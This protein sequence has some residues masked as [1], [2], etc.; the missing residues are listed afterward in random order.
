MHTYNREEYEYK[1]AWQEDMNG[2]W[3]TA[4]GNSYTIT[5]SVT[6]FHGTF[7]DIILSSNIKYIIK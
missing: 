3:G 7:G 1:L 6:I 2:K 4:Y 5:G